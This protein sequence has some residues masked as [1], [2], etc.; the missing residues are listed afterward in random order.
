MS[1]ARAQGAFSP[2]DAV[3]LEGAVP[4]RRPDEDR[5]ALAARCRDADWVPKV[6]LAGQMVRAPDGTLMQVMHNGV[7]VAA[8]GYYGDW[9]QRLIAACRGHH[10][11]QEE[12]GF[13]ALLPHLP[14]DAAMIELGGHWSYYTL[15]FLCRQPTR[16]GIVV[17]PDP[18]Y[19][20]V[21]RRNA[22]LNHC[23]P[24]FIHACAGGA[25]AAPAPFATETSGVIE[26]PCVSVPGL[27]AAHGI[28]HL[29]LL[30]CDAQGVE[31]AVLCSCLALGQAGQLEWFVIS[32]HS[33]HI[34][35]DPLTHQRCLAAL[36][37]AGAT[38]LLEHDVQE[39]FSGDGLIIGKFGPVPAG[40]ERPPF[41]YNR[42]S[43]SLFRHP[44]HDLAD[45]RASLQST[46][47]RH[48]DLY[49]WRG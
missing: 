1:Q 13:A 32:T 12:S 6:A 3:P 41:S 40:W 9:S 28:S 38:I 20:A 33:H 30:H 26:L 7:L 22:A 45:V 23:E 27:M 46:D 18:A 24:V 31:L 34:T 16:R 49:L 36:T 37:A 35:G 15:W 5:I 29:D 43:D 11:P 39:S 2:A 48:A 8:G 44:L 25:D 19:L 17:E 47:G 42:A 10:E 4:V 14:A 21:G